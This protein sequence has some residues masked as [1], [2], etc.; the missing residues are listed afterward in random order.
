MALCYADSKSL[1]EMEKEEELSWCF[2]HMSG[3]GCLIGCSAV[4]GTV[5]NRNVVHNLLISM[6]LSN[7]S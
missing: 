4:A 1:A 3:G 7:N 6:S 5:F 2:Q